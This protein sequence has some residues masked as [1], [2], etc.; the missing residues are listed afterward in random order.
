M[1]RSVFSKTFY[2]KRW[3]LF[4]WMLGAVGLFAFTAAFFPAFRDSGLDQIMKTIPPAMKSMLGNMAEMNTFAGYVGSAVFGLRAQLLFIPLAIILGLS[5]GVGEEARGKLY[6]LFAQ[7]VS[8]A[9]VAWQKYLAGL[10]IVTLIVGLGVASVGVTA[11]LL[12]ETV[13]YVL[14]GKICAMAVL[15]TA[16]LFS[17]TYCLGIAFGRRS[18]ALI[19]PIIWVL[20]SILS[21]ALSG[22]VDWLRP[23]DYAS[24]LHYFHTTDLVHQAINFKHIGALS[25]ATVLPLLVALVVF[26]NR[27]LH[28]E[29]A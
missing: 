6:Q 24:L 1:F 29:V 26:Q 20:F 10:V 21:D 13:P 28:E 19:I 9:S 14:L 22:Q 5:L 15:F 3:F 4:G 25:A 23:V 17:V 7:P 18:I 27:D 2:D 16:A 11:A 8:R 12:G